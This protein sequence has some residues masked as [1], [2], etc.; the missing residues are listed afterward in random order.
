MEFEEKLVQYILCITKHRQRCTV[1]LRFKVG[2]VLALDIN[3][4][5]IP[6]ILD[7]IAFLCCIS[8]PYIVL[9]W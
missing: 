7:K 6:D 4:L 8:V 2:S 9:L 5:V 3:V 1:K